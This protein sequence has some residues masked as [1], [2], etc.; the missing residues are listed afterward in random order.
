MGEKMFVGVDPGKSGHCVMIQGNTVTKFRF[1]IIGTEYDLQGMLDIFRNFEKDNCHIVVEDVKAL[2]KPF[3]AG[4]WSLA[5]GKTILVMSC[6]ALKLPYTLVHSKTWQRE[7]WQ[8]VKVQQ[9]D[10]GKKT[11]KG[12]PKYET[13]TKETTLLAIKRLFPDA[14]LRI[15]ERAVKPDDGVIDALAL[16]EY[17]RRNFR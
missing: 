16:A 10:T 13:L 7:L 5:E 6:V 9:R 14:D 3:Q 2:Q 12:E 1:P 15:S 11:A 4:N 17:C 8:G